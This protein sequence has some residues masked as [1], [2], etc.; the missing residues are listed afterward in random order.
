MF[1]FR[2][3]PLKT[4]AILAAGFILLRIAYRALFNGLNGAGVLLLDVPAVRLPPPFAHVALFGPVTTGGLQTAVLSALPIALVILAF[5]ALNAVVDVSRLFARGARSGPLR[6][7]SRAL[8]IA[9][10]TFPALTDAVASVRVARRLRAERGTASLLVP[11]FERTVERAVAVAATME[12]RGFAATRPAAGVCEKPVVL[13]GVGIGYDGRRMLR[14]LDLDL[15]TGTLTVIAGP[16][17]CGKTTL[18]HALSGLLTHVDGGEVD[19]R[20]EVGG[21]DRLAVAPRDTAGFVGVVLQQPRLGFASETVA[22]EIGFALDVRGVASVIVAARVT[23]VAEHVGIAHLVGRDI[24]SLS[25]GEATLVAIAAA[26]VER[27]TVLLVDE[28]LADLDLEA[29]ARIVGLLAGLAHDAGV[30]VVVAEHRVGEL[31][32][33]ADAVLTVTGGRL[34]AAESFG[35]DASP[36]ASRRRVRR[37]ALPFLGGAAV[38]PGA[39]RRN[40]SAAGGCG[41]WRCRRRGVWRCYGRRRWR[42]R[43]RDP[44]PVGD[45][46]RHAGRGR[47]E[48]RPFGG[49]GRGDHRGERRGQVEPADRHRPAVDGHR[50]GGWSRRRHPRTA[51][52]TP[53]GRAGARRV[54][55]PV[56]LHHRGR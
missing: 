10:A 31:A 55:R 12:V 25:A 23:E 47:R 49:R 40:D 29:R 14:D 9:W 17:G 35:A 32:G 19:G 20:V 3:A 4:A 18:L 7:L 41:R 28:P 16:T 6:G 21:V 1:R 2:T 45:A 56:V 39:R 5:G 44:R 54:R 15:T 51:G 46:C 38:V 52:Q 13:R 27:P 11:L 42:C 53:A 36:A 50:A 22:D 26:I 34:L 43:R 33:V 8:V 24:R 37:R 48:A 30:C